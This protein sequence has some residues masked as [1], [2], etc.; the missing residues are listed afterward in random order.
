[1]GTPQQIYN[2]DLGVNY[3][4][5]G[6]TYLLSKK[7]KHAIVYISCGNILKVVNNDPFNPESEIAKPLKQIFIPTPEF[8][9]LNK[10]PQLNPADYPDTV[11]GIY[12]SP[13]GIYRRKY[14]TVS[15]DIEGIEE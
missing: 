10:Q 3:D 2:N 4:D 11:L 13:N 12:N 6:I 14:T 7:T 8:E 5:T 9:L 15:N 1:L